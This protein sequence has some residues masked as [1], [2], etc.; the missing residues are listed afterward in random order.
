M[1]FYVKK[2]PEL[3]KPNLRTS[4]HINKTNASLNMQIPILMYEPV[5]TLGNYLAQLNLFLLKKYLFQ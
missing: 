1:Y 5:V 4:I 2:V 3:Q